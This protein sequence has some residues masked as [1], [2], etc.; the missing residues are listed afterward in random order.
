MSAP[1]FPK[2]LI[3]S[4]LLIFKLYILK[5]SLATAAASA[6]PPPNPA[7][8]GIFFLI[9]TSKLLEILYFFLRKFRVFSTIVSPPIFLRFLENSP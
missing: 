9:I 4:L 7:P 6:D 1:I 8:R 2:E 3:I 5:I